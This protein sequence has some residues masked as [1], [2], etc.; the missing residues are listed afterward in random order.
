MNY[1]QELNI[2][3]NASDREIRKAYKKL[4]LKYQFLLFFS[5]KMSGDP[6]GFSMR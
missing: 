3:K 6:C 1:Y 4:A 5:W 2:K